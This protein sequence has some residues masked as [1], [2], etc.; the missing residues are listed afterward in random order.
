[1]RQAR[2]SNGLDVCNANSRWARRAHLE[3][4]APAEVSFEGLDVEVSGTD[5]AW[6]Y[7]LVAALAH[8]PIQD[9]ITRE[10]A[11]QVALGSS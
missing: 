9:A 1:M 8:S 10:V 2:R 11:A 6:L 5:L 7:N 3:A 4:A